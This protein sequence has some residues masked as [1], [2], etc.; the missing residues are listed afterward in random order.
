MFD[1]L[2]TEEN[3]QRYKN[4]VTFAE[5]YNK[6]Y[7]KTF[8]L[9]QFALA[10]V[11]AHKRVDGCVI[12]ASNKAQIAESV[13]ALELSKNFTQEDL[14]S[15]YTVKLKPKPDPPLDYITLCDGT[16]CR[17]ISKLIM[18][19]GGLSKINN[20][21]QLFELLNATIAM[22]INTFDTAP[23]YPDAENLLGK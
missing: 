12:G 14:N 17:N 23:I 18:G 13:A 19:T 7:G 15:L 11:L 3:E 2:F 21:T 8:S 4:L 22:G 1:A 16:L 10:Y 20:Q 9:A 5:S 6:K